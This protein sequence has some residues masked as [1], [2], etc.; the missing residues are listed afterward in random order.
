[1]G[2]TI[3]GM[4][5]PIVEPAGGE[6]AADA[7]MVT[8]DSS[9]GAKIALFRSLFRGRSDVYPRR[10]ESRRT[11]RAGYAAGLRQRVGPRDSARS[12]GSSAATV[13][14]APSCR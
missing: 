4:S 7:T 8:R 6:S 2:A 5:R 9:A 12:P 11:G 10:F 14:T 13:R 1:M 3:Q